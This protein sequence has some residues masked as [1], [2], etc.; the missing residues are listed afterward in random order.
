MVIGIFTIILLKP[1]YS[2]RISLFGKKLFSDVFLTIIKQFLLLIST[3]K[4]TYASAYFS[5]LSK[6]AHSFISK[7]ASGI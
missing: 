1:I 7:A 5:D 4:I 3:P 2:N 6:Q